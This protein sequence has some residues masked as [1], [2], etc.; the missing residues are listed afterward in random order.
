MKKALYGLKQDDMLITV[1]NE[2]EISRLR[3]GLAIR[4]E[5]KILG[6]IGCFLGLEVERTDQG[7]FISLRNY[8]KNLLERFGM[9]ES[10]G[11]ATSME[12]Y[13][14][15][16]KEE[17]KLFKDERRFLTTCWQLNLFNN[18]KTGNCILS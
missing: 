11:I 9:E 2:A 3:N 13:L 6:E 7:F 8:A 10:N 15:L 14:K 1:G 18:Y 5:M 17:G 4:F 12:P 16:N